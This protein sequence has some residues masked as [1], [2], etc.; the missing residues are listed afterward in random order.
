MGPGMADTQIEPNQI[1]GKNVSEKTVYVAIAGAAETL[2]PYGVVSLLQ[3][4]GVI[5]MLWGYSLR[6]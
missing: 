2:T 6:T 5:G 4:D 1:T 3:R